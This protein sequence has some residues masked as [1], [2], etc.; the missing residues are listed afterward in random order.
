MVSPCHESLNK[1][2]PEHP[3]KTP[4]MTVVAAVL[5]DP[6]GR[7]LIAQRPNNKHMGGMWEFPGGKLE[8]GEIPEFG[9]MRELRE[10]LGIESRP[11]CFT[12]ISFASHQYD[13]FHLLMPL[14]ALRIWRNHPK[15]IEH[16]ALKWI[17][18]HQLFDFDMPPA[19]APLNDAVI[20]YLSA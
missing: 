3:K 16:Q 20:R 18:P 13:D 2:P 6:D 11:G 5:I 8:D 17:R 7:I 9:L 10:E 12:P 4:I 15:A 1:P 19:D 14:Y